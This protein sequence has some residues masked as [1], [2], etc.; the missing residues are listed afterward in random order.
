M[1]MKIKYNKYVGIA[2]LVFAGLGFAGRFWALPML[3]LVEHVIYFII[4][5]GILHGLW[6]AYYV[7]NEQLNIHLPYEKGVV[8]RI[9]AQLVLGWLL[10][11]GL[12]IPLA[13]Y[14][15]Q[16]LMPMP[17]ISFD[18]LHLIFIGLTAFFG[19]SVMNLGFI[20]NHFF[21][22]W[23]ANAVRAAHLEKEK[24]Q[25]QFD[26][27][28]NQ[29]NPHFLFNSLASLDSLILDQ[30]DLARQF[31]RQLS[32]VYR[33]ALKS[34]DSALVSLE[35]EVEF[36]R[37]YISLLTTRFNDQ[38]SIE[39]NLDPGTLDYQVVPMTLQMLLENAIKHNR[40][41]ASSPLRVRIESTGLWLQVSNSICLKER[42]E[43]SNGKGLESLSSLYEFLGNR[44][45]EVK[46]D[47]A[48]FRVQIPL[49]VKGLT[50][51]SEV[52]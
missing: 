38:L 8:K 36:V 4:Q 11:E 14:A 40:V 13:M 18:K 10:I 28:K 30:P 51:L 5:I 46:S 15:Y 21:E 32:K 12:M 20:A 49:F 41:N 3:S 22:Q 6:L 37:N 34:Q 29:L 19:S 33:Y 39:I 2:I 9:I 1:D 35:E 24:A 52:S 42:V 23:R 7:L 50:E 47:E 25:V 44:P 48:W 31:L 17:L 45:L 26:N 16:R 27:L 43:T